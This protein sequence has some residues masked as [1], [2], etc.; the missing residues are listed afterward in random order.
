MKTMRYVLFLM[1][2]ALMDGGVGVA[3]NYQPSEAN[4]RAREWFQ[5]AKFGMF[6][7]WGVYSVPAGDAWVMEQPKLPIVEQEQFVPQFNPT[8]FNAAEILALAKSAGMKYITITSK[9]HDGFAM[10]GTQQ[11]KWNIVDATHYGKDPL[12]QLAE[13]CRKQELSY[14]SITR[15]LTGIIPTTGLWAGPGIRRVAR[16]EETLITILISWMLNSRSC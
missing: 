9:H 3:Q 12:K 16:R 6:I 1:M 7:H 13:E 15:S 5:D 14:S 10:W 8:D 11:T 2:L 4:L